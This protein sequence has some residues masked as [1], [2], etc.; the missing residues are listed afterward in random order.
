MNEERQRRNI[1]RLEAKRRAINERMEQQLRRINT[2]FDQKQA[3]LN[4]RLNVKQ[5]QI[6]AAALELLSEQGLSNLSLRDIAKRL[7]MQ[8][9]ALYWHFKNK[10]DLVDYMAEAILQ[11]ELHNLQARTDDEAW[12]DWLTN[13]MIRLRRAMLGY[14]DGARVVAGAHFYPAVT[15]ARITETTLAS[16]ESAG[17]DLQIARHISMTAA[18]Y[19]FGYVIEEQS[20]PNAEHLDKINLAEFLAP[21]PTLARSMQN[22]RF[23]KKQ[24][25]EDYA[26]GLRYIVDGSNN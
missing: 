8:A 9:P 7:G 4:G 2:R 3:Q 10:D 14:P 17:I 12:Q 24:A 22:V 25:D 1:E 13:V 11:K 5:E 23:T 21:Y 26:I 16:L 15:L 18:N 6:V 19:T 20:G